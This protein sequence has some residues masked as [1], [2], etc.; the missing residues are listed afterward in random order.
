MKKVRVLILF[1]LIMGHG[2]SVLLRTVGT[3]F[4]AH[5]IG[6]STCSAGRDSMLELK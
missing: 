5:S 2:T 3:D 4:A 1:L 6:F